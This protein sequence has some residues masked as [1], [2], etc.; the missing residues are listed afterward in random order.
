[1]INLTLGD[2]RIYTLDENNIVLAKCSFVTKPTSK[3]YGKSTQRVLGY[4]SSMK[5]A[6]SDYMAKEMASPDYCAETVEQLEA[7]LDNIASRI[8]KALEEIKYGNQ[9]K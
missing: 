9:S 4:Y 1:M 3:N 2:Y 8:E 7:V 6:L 5:S